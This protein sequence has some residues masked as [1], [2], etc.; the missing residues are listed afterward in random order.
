MLKDQII[1][2]LDE[3][4]CCASSYIA[5]TMN[6]P[7]EVVQ[8]LCRELA[9]DEKIILISAGWDFSLAWT[10]PDY[11]EAFNEEANSRPDWYLSPIQRWYEIQE[12]S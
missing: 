5:Q 9:R 1:E 4:I 3:E 8:G 10:L 6:I 11:E 7:V 2:L 12:A